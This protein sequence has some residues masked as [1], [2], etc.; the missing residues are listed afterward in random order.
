M[1]EIG[2]LDFWGRGAEL[3]D[4]N[5]IKHQGVDLHLSS[6]VEIRMNWVGQEE[7]VRQLKAA[8]LVTDDSDLPMNPRLI[9]KPGVGKTTLAYTV[10]KNLGRSVYLFQA[11]MDTRPEDLIIT[12]V[13]TE[14]QT[15]KYVAS[16]L[17]SAM[18]KGGVCILDEG[19]RMSEKSWASLAPL[20]D[21][22]RYVESLV[23]GITVKANPEFRFATTM[24]EDSSTYEIPEYIFSRIQPGIYIDFPCE[25]E[26]KAILKAN[27]PMVPEELLAYVVSFLQL[28]HTQNELYT[29]RD[30]INIAR[31]GF[32]LVK[33]QGLSLKAAFEKSVEMVLRRSDSDDL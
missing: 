25:N 6:P 9:G 22:R 1:L 31:Y 2:V 26:E 17:V 21:H 30:G 8:W 13:I 27:V 32:K 24:N 29:V 16:P 3:K 18:L 23:A 4:P 7:V 28:S 5:I 12:P 19:N 15:I 14:N 10:S 11:T 20:L 33:S